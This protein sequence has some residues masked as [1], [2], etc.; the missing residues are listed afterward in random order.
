MWP[1][2][3]W[4]F[5]FPIICS[6]Y[7]L[8]VIGFILF[9]FQDLKHLKGITATYRMTN[10][11]PVRHS[12]YVSGVLRPLKVC[13]FLLCC[14]L[15]LCPFKK[16]DKSHFLW[17]VSCRK[18]CDIVGFKVFWLDAS[19]NLLCYLFGLNYL[20]S[21][22]LIIVTYWIF[23]IFTWVGSMWMCIYFLVSCNLKH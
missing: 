7:F 2:C 1:T 12:P 11:L 4:Q 18:H 5:P 13:D 17:W 10:K 3:A 6:Y 16:Y 23:S 15:E 21:I 19:K 20:L 14:D 9:N 22:S 8:P